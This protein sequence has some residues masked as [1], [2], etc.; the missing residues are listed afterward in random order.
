M[1]SIITTFASVVAAILAWLAKIRWSREYASAKDEIIRSKDANIT[2]LQ[3]D[4]K[5]VIEAKDS[6]I[7]RLESEIDLLQKFNSETLKTQYLSVKGQLEDRVNELQKQLDDTKA[8]NATLNQNSPDALKEGAFRINLEKQNLE[9]FL[10]SLKE[11]IDQYRDHEA[12]VIKLAHTDFL[13]NLP[14]RA[15]V[16]SKGRQLDADHKSYLTAIID[17]DKFKVVNDQHGHVEGDRL[18][19][20]IAMSLAQTMG[21]NNFVARMGGD[22]FAVLLIDYSA[23][24]AQKTLHQFI[25]HLPKISDLAGKYQMSASIG[26][27]S[28]CPEDIEL[29]LRHADIAM[30]NAKQQGRGRT[31]I[32]DPSMEAYLEHCR[33]SHK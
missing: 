2:N 18:L 21:P 27:S 24:A 32:F 11:R 20:S 13:T 17:L 14:N 5:L 29:K 25:E 1:L 8:E 7:K 23:D 15:A 19:K 12:K 30:Y 31:V 9:R 4:Y 6:H 28:N 33:Q 16:Y 26:L 22:E 10:D 3:S